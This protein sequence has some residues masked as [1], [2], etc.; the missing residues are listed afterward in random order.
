M[1]QANVRRRSPPIIIGD[2]DY[3]RLTRLASAAPPALAD[4]AEELLREMDRARL[5]PQSDIPSNVVRIG[6]L[7]TFQPVSGAVRTVRL[8]FPGQADIA[9]GRISV[10]TPIGAALIGLAEGQSMSWEDRSGRRHEL[11]VLSVKWPDAP[12]SGDRQ[13]AGAQA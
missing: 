6:S 12:A 4:A 10:L 9:E 7:V 3:E 13:V 11:T 8:V 5:K 1:N 2:Q